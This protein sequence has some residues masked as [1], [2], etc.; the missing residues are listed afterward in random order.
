MDSKHKLYRLTKA[1]SRS[2]HIGIDAGLKRRIAATWL[3]L[4][5]LKA[6]RSKRRSVNVLGYNV[7]FPDLRLISGLFNEIYL[8]NEYYFKSNEHNPLII[9]CGSNIG[10]S[11]LYFKIIEPKCRIICFE[12]DSEAYSYLKT[13]IK[14]NNLNYI[15]IH[16]VALYSEETLIDFY[17]DPENF[18]SPRMS[19]MRDRMNGGKRTVRAVPLSR[20]INEPVDFLKMDIEGAELDVLKE[21]RD[22]GKLSF[23]KRM[24]IEYHHHVTMHVDN[25]ST[26]LAL[27]EN[28]GYG[29]HIDGHINTPNSSNMFQDIMIYAYQK[30]TLIGSFGEEGVDRSQ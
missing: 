26:M 15:Q 16:N 9:D 29:Y 2:G 30:T 25:M 18:A 4:L 10:M 11:T 14:Q 3:K 22:S 5:A 21:L 8:S 12:P 28:A 27:L 17:Y 20:Y 7:D 19:L 24:A 13:N 6:I 1:L 23:V